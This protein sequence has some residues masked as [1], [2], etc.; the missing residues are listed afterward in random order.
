MVK[1]NVL[2][3]LHFAYNEQAELLKSAHD[4][5]SLNRASKRDYESVVNYFNTCD[6][7]CND[8]SYIFRKEDI[9][10]LKPGREESFLDSLI[11]KL[12][13]KFSYN[14]IQVTLSDIHDRLHAY[15]AYF[16][17]RD[18]SVVMTS[19]KRQDPIPKVS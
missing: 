19:G 11:E 8:E 4:L 13:Q 5:T 9:I 14:F 18:G 15:I 7:V 10:T 16:A 3:V 1:L 17:P 12:L 6:P 2:D